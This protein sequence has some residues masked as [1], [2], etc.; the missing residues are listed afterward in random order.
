MKSYPKISVVIP[1]YK[2]EKYIAACIDRVLAQS[3]SD[4]ELLLVLDGSFDQSESISKDYAQKDT[5][6]KILKE[7]HAG[8]AHVR[9]VGLNESKGDYLIY[10]DADDEIEPT[11]L[12]ELYNKAIV[13][14]A[15]MVVCDYA[16]LTSE[17]K[18]ERCQQPSELT[19]IAYFNDILAGKCYGALWNKLMKRTVVLES[20]AAFPLNLSMREDLVFLSYLLPFITKLSYLSRCL[21]GYERRN[22]GSLT[23]N[24]LDESK[25]YYG[26]E[27]GWNSLILKNKYLKP[28]MYARMISYYHELAYI[29]LR[30]DLFTQK[31][32]HY[33]FLPFKKELKEVGH[34]YKG[35]I[36]KT[37]L[38]V[39]FQVARLLRKLICK[40]RN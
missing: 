14:G 23:N 36:V 24:Y 3:F 35:L 20:G 29:T 18:I 13:D 10:V 15:D 2:A 33:Y 6:I 8:V 9:Q 22:V 31:E 25:R 21:Y 38:A 4:F 17:G 27:V 34:G 1:V 40:L 5:R 39:N 11:Y 26:Q 30:P 12:E 28:E 19:G 37:A 32:W 16:E 7:E